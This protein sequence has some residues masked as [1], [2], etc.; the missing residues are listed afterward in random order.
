MW[1][2]EKN[3]YTRL[4]EGNELEKNQID[5]T[6]FTDILYTLKEDF[7]VNFVEHITQC[8]LLFF[9]FLRSLIT[10]IFSTFLRERSDWW[11][12]KDL[13][14]GPIGYEPSALTN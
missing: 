1:Y 9:S 8:N 6:K 5:Q 10:F 14:L 11:A 7:S 13:N 2:F 4:I 12:H 3:P